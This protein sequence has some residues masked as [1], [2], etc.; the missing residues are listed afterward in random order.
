MFPRVEDAEYVFFDVTADSWPIH[1]NDQWRLYQSLVTEEGFG[2]LA[3][4]DG[5]VLLRRGVTDGEGLPDSFYSFAR[6][7]EP[8]IEYP[9]GIE[10]GDVLRFLGFDLHQDGDQTSLSLCWQAMVPLERDYLIYPF[11]YDD[12]GRIIEDTTLRPMTTAI[13]YPTSLW[14]PDEIVC[15]DTL[16]WDVGSDFHIGL[17]V[18][19][20]DSWPVQEQR[21]EASVVTSAL[22]V[23][24][25]DEDTAVQLA[26]VREGRITTPRRLFALPDTAQPLKSGVGEQIE[27]LGY[28]LVPEAPSLD[29]AL[30]VRL[31]WQA[32][33]DVA[34]DYTVFTHLVDEAETIVAQHDGQPDGGRYPT[35][36]W[37][38]GEVVEDEHP[39]MPAPGFALGDYTVVV[40]MYE[41]ESGERLPAYDEH[42]Q[43]WPQGRVVLT[44]LQVEE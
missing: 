17:G 14:K 16:P 29:E 38:Q 4:K 9:A 10:F 21:L 18:V 20:G 26:D 2:V 43:P 44:T 13:W 22:R 36:H 42:G 37:L 41:L 35:S 25:F 28:Q 3:A 30:R 33:D 32:A 24:L 15:M 7:E 5:Y 11:F 31:Y 19:D 40:G 27:L 8:A 39:L 34:V 6:R 12:G 23:H 1:P